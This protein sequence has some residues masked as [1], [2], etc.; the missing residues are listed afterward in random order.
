MSIEVDEGPIGKRPGGA[1]DLYVSS[2]MPARGLRAVLGILH[3]YADHGARYRHVM[4]ALAEHGIGSIAVDMRGHGRAAGTRGFCTQFSEFTDDA[5]VLRRLVDERAAGAP[6]FLFGHS[7]GGLVASTSVIDHSRALRGLILSA[8]FFGL[9]LEVPQ[10]KILAGKVASK[11]YPRLGL[12]SGLFGKDMSHDPA[13]AKA[14]DDDPLIFSKATARWF[15]ETVAAQARA[16]QNAPRLT[17]PLFLSFGTADK[18]ASIDAARRFFDLAG[19]KDK[20]WDAREGLFHEVLNEPSWK[21]LVE[22]FAQWILAR[23]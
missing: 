10:V 12:P 17:L 22:T 8:P 16:F 4:G 21:E 18:V 6:T 11:L 13:K 9:A 15:T 14:Y 23:A 2:T 5:E 3:G 20:T 7:F 19:S 1:P